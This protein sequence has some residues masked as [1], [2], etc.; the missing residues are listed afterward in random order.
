M[1]VRIWQVIYFA[2]LA[3]NHT[4]TSITGDGP[5]DAHAGRVV[6]MGSS[7]QPQLAAPSC[8]HR[9]ESICSKQRGS[10]GHLGLLYWFRL[11]GPCPRFVFLV[12]WLVQGP[13]PLLPSDGDPGWHRLPISSRPCCCRRQTLFCWVKAQDYRNS[14]VPSSVSRFVS[15]AQRT[16]LLWFGVAGGLGEHYFL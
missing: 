13:S 7:P 8:T 16:L 1:E 11:Q 10:L 5:C 12:G 14:P 6:L 9:M 15:P 4:S 3:L 2:S